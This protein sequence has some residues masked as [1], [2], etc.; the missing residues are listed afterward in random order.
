MRLRCILAEK[1]QYILVYKKIIFVLHINIYII[2]ITDNLPNKHTLLGLL[3][4][5]WEKYS[6]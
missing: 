5:L 3:Y 6:E 4:Y 1:S 2:S